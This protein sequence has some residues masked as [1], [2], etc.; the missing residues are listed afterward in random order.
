M[1]WSESWSVMSDSLQPRGL[2]SSWGFPG[3]NT[4]VGSL[5]FLQGFFSIQGLNPSLP[6]C[7]QTLYQL[8]HQ[9]RKFWNRIRRCFLK[10]VILSSTHWQQGICKRL[11][12]STVTEH[13]EGKKRKDLSQNCLFQ[14]DKNYCKWKHMEVHTVKSEFS[15]KSTGRK[16]WGEDF[17]WMVNI[18]AVIIF[19]F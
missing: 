7:R 19:G 2:Y 14:E 16:K 9:G 15:F 1:K 13:S 11:D 17:I 5:S 18:I 3:Q 8:S 6:H 10:L 12:W 4:G